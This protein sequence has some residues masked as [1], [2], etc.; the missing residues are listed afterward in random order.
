MVIRANVCIQGCPTLFDSWRVNPVG[1]AAQGP[2]PVSVAESGIGLGV[3]MEDTP[4]LT[5]RRPGDQSPRLHG[6]SAGRGT[7]VP[8]SRLEYPSPMTLIS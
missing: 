1:A 3:T 5:I 2:T 6:A 8:I 7:Q 4:Y